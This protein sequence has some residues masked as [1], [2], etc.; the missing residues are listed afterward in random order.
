MQA[1]SLGLEAGSALGEA[2]L[3]PYF[4]RA[5]DKY[6]VEL[7]I[8]YRG[9][10]TLARRS[11]SIKG[12]DSRPVFE[13]E[14]FEVDYGTRPGIVHR[15]N[16]TGARTPDKLTAVYTVWYLEDGAVQFDV[17]SK[18]EVESCI[19]CAFRARRTASMEEHGFIEMASEYVERVA[20]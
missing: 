5:D 6:V 9:L 17:M 10:V 14:Q 16:F 1:A 2:Y 18:N 3:V 11:G 8:G 7:I 13:G 20:R 19:R 4:S 12:L 15:P